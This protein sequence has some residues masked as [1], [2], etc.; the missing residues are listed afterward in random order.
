[1][2]FWILIILGKLITD[3]MENFTVTVKRM[4][5][6]F[7]FALQDQPVWNNINLM[8]ILLSCLLILNDMYIYRYI[9]TQTHFKLLLL[10]YSYL[11]WFEVYYKLLNT[12]ADYLTKELVSSV[13]FPI[14]KIVI[15]YT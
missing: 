5:A 13:F 14:L 7:F 15:K 9:Y 2:E 12:L 3:H 10:F 1:M 11:P 4:W 6:L 8:F